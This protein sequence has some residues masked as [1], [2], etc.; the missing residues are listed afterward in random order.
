[1]LLTRRQ[2]LAGALQALAAVG[3]AGCRPFG[4]PAAHPKPHASP[5]QTDALLPL[6]VAE[7]AVLK[8]YDD[9]LARYPQLLARVGVIRAD[10]AAH[11]DALR[12][13][14]AGPD[15]PAPEGPAF[16]P[17]TPAAAL[18]GLRATE[19]NAAA[20]LATACAFA[21]PARAALLGSVAACESAHLVLLR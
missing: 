21:A 18:A 2:M 3:L 9:V 20:R 15:R 12:G 10:H 14:L 7:R 13:A 6:V 17:A 8:Q 16:A 1:M 19:A 11:L 5:P 4:R